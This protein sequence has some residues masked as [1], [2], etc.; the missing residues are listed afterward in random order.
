MGDGNV[1]VQV[2]LKLVVLIVTE[3]FV[4][5]A[6]HEQENTLPFVL[7]QQMYKMVSKCLNVLSHTLKKKLNHVSG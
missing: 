4:T 7:G 3:K 2:T 5:L 1:C 6:G